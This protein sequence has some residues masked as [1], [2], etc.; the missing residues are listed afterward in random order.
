[1]KPELK[2]KTA[3]PSKSLESAMNDPAFQHQKE[4]IAFLL[5]NKGENLFPAKDL[6]EQK[7][8]CKAKMERLANQQPGLLLKDALA[9]ILKDL[10]A[11]FPPE[12][13]QPLTKYLIQTWMKAQQKELA[14]A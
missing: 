10:P 4:M 11:T 7:R 9:N 12:Q 6:A 13:L 1:M 2:N 8:L 3:N 14:V 5:K